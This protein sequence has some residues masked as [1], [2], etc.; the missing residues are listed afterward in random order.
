MAQHKRD[1]YEILGVERSATADEIKKAYRKCALEHHPDRNPGNKRSEELFKEATEA[2]Q[3]LA[4][5]EKRSLYDR[6]GH[7]G[8]TGLGGGFSEATGFGDI[9]QD[10]F[11]D[12]FGSAT[13]R[14]RSRPQRGNDLGHEIEI[15]FLEAAF[16]VEKDVDVKREELCSACRGDGAKPGTPRKTCNACHGTGQ[17]LASSGFFSI[18]RTCGRCRGQGSFIEHP[19]GACQGQGRILIDRRIH[20]RIP[21]GA[22]NGLRLRMTG[23]GEAGSRGGPR[24]DLYVDIRVR[25]HEFFTR[26]REDLHCEVPISFVQAALGCEIRVP[27][28][29]GPV[30]QKIPAGTQHG[31]VFKLKGR[32]LPS[33]RGGPAGDEHVKI[34]VETPTHL[35]ERQKELLREFA[36]ISGEKANPMAAS[37]MEKVRKVFN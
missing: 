17:V 1:Y 19:C 14:G 23:E 6:Y 24:G 12:F 25:P 18:S 15:G 10:I 8:V 29:H 28:L 33:L 36:S 13:G 2:Y 4:D 3:V 34:A 11:E 21:A 32:G 37:F 7:E 16:G 30:V 5:T 20:I 9:F 22:D 26:D 27:T 35:T 31:K